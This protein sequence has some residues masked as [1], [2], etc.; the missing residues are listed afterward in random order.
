MMELT[1][2]SNH[3]RLFSFT[4]KINSQYF[5]A[6][7]SKRVPITLSFEDLTEADQDLLASATI[8]YYTH[9]QFE[10][11]S[12]EIDRFECYPLA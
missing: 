1:A 7:I 11:S 9:P 2:V 12:C 8:H 5:D 4:S 6:T 3:N 10:G